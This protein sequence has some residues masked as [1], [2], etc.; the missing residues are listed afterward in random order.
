MRSAWD[1]TKRIEFLTWLITC[2]PADYLVEFELAEL[3]IELNECLAR[4]AIDMYVE[5]G[6]HPSNSQTE[7][8]SKVS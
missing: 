2:D 5:R 6:F 3:K 4:Q 1:L 8:E 7:D